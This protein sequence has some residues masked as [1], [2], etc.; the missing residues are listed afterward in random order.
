MDLKQ[1]Q[2]V[3]SK[4]GR[5]KGRLY[6]IIGLEKDRVLLSDGRYRPVTMPKRKNAKHLQPYHNVDREIKEKIRHRK[7]DDTVVRQ[8]IK[9]MISVQEVQKDNELGSSFCLRI[10]SCESA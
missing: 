5:D 3:K 6:I 9:E 8:Y 1:G 7:L 2:L 4:A 10:S